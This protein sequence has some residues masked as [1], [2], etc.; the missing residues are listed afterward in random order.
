MDLVVAAV[1]R[2]LR[3]VGVLGLLMFEVDTLFDW[4]VVLV[5][6]VLTGFVVVLIG[7]AVILVDFVVAL[8]GFEVDLIS[9]VVGSVG[10]EV[11]LGDFADL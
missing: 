6:V 10:F 3:L 8:T 5:V 7:C 9:C 1:V 2:V 4:R 11:G